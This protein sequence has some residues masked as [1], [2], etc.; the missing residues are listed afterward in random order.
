MERQLEL[1]LGL[2][3]EGVATE[4]DRELELQLE[5]VLESGDGAGDGSEG[6]CEGVRWVGFGVRT[7]VERLPEGGQ[8]LKM[9]G[10]CLLGGVEY[11][12]MDVEARSEYEFVSKPKMTQD[13]CQKQMLLPIRPQDDP[14]MTPRCNQD[15]PKMQPRR[16]T[17]DCNVK[18]V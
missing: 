12:I 6:K 18:L 5:V 8:S 7:H 2:E 17:H 10:V 9:D 13:G 4:R 3:L 15:G 16:A 14:K 1:E 11:W